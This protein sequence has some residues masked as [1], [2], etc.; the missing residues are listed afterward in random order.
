MKSVGGRARQEEGVLKAGTRQVEKEL[1]AEL[2]GEEER[3]AV[4][5]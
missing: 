1:R 5:L 4:G 2:K 3:Y